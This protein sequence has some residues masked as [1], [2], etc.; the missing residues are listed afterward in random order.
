MCRSY[1]NVNFNTV[2][3]TITCAFVCEQ[4]TW[5]LN[6]SFEVFLSVHLRRFPHIS[7]YALLCLFCYEELTLEFCPSVVDP[8]CMYICMYV[9]VCVYI[10]IYIYIYIYRVDLQCLNKILGWVLRSKP[11]TKV[12]KNAC[13]EI[14]A[15]IYIPLMILTVIIGI[16][17]EHH[18]SM[19]F[20][21]ATVCVLCKGGTSFLYIT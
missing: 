1:F 12:R 21:M 9:R 3:K 18:W 8:P 20:I 6:N 15:Y 13:A 10:Y 19:I 11:N 4:I 7:S 5:T 16:I 17:P 2:F 14:D